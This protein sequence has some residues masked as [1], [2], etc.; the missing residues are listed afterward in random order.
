MN[1]DTFQVFI[2][3]K[4]YNTDLGNIK[5]KKNSKAKNEKNERILS[6]KPVAHTSHIS[7]KLIY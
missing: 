3:R 5:I 2:S 7:T 6:A 1:V 4:K